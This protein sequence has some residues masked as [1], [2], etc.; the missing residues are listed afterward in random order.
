MR[1]PTTL[2]RLL[3]GLA[4]GSVAALTAG[5]LGAAPA[6]AATPAEGTVVAAN[7]ANAI[8]DR[9][10][11]VLKTTAK[12]GTAHDLAARYHG[13]VTAE[14]GTAV[15]GFTVT[16]SEKAAKRLAAN[17]AV[18][19]V[20][21]DRTV[22]A[23]E[24]QTGAPWG[25]DRIDQRTLPL[26]GTYT[27]PNTAANVTAYI[28]DTGVRLT[29]TEF[30]GRARSGYDFID[31]DTD[32]T[33]CQGHGTHVAGTVAG[34]TH[35]VA[36]QAKI[37]SVRVLDCNGSGSYSAIIA[38]VDWVTKNAIKPAVANMSLGG[39]ASTTLDTA[40]K[41]SIASGVTYTLAAGNENKDACTVS[42][43]RQPDAITVAATEPTDAR[44]SYS[45][46]GTCVDLF[47]PGSSILSATKT[48]D[49]STGKMSGTSMATP[50][51]AGIAALYLAANPTW[52]PAQVRT[53]MLTDTTPNK[54]TNP[55]NGTPN[56]LAY[57]GNIKAVVPTTAA[58]TTVYIINPTQFPIADLATVESPITVANAA[59]NGSGTAVVKVSARHTDRGDLAV[60][61]IAP[62]GTPYPLKAA[63]SGDDVANFNAVY[64]VNLS[65][66]VRAGTWKLRVQDQFAGDTGILDTWNLTV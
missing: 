29:H 30:A 42:P 25:L 5:A 51:V 59:G 60:S 52:T 43:A 14:Y 11:V 62:D 12:T 47:A 37:V 28:L 57:T 63:T 53:A 64:T 54:I 33:D 26:A 19:T 1:T 32:A 61:L 48:S 58:G 17:P 46:Y 23:T 56:K 6:T 13:T 49:T 65:G 7:A 22:A 21:Q 45:N 15:N 2:N 18:A 40:V 50:H 34:K 16:L 39:S 3:A 9:Y 44:A 31:K 24:T 10:I 41:N 35:G 8:K 66:E 55:G 20:E 36:K 4:A 38:G 27:H